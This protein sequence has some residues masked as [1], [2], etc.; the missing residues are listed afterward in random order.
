MKCGRSGAWMGT[1]GSTPHSM[2]R[3]IHEIVAQTDL[4][5]GLS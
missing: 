5:P 2:V 3:T 1:F 4:R